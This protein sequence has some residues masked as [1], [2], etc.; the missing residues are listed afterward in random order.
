MQYDAHNETWTGPEKLTFRFVFVYVL[1]FLSCFSFPHAIIPDIGKY[2]SVF[3]Q[4]IVTWFVKHV[5][6]LSTP[7]NIELHSDSTGMYVAALMMLAVAAIITI[8][9]SFADRNRNNYNKLN[10][11]FRVFTSYYLALQLLVYGADKIFKAQFYLPEPNTLY[12][13]LGNM[14]RDLLY[15]STMGVSRP[16]SI[17]LGSV[18]VACALLLLFRRSRMAGAILAVFV[19]ANIV[20]INF[21]FDIS[22]KL[23]SLYLLALALLLVWPYAYARLRNRQ[24]KLWLPSFDSKQ[25]RGIYISIKVACVILI[26]ADASWAY[27]H[28]SNFN[29]DT[30]PRPFLHGAY[31]V[32]LFV[33]NNDTLPPL[34]TDTARWRRMFIHRRGYFIAQHMNDELKD[35]TLIYDTAN[36][37]LMISDAR[38]RPQGLF[39]YERPNDSAL[40]LHGD[41]G[42][43]SVNIYLRKLDEGRLRLYNAPF[44][45][46]S[47]E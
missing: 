20:A 21:C 10:Y 4:P 39:Q 5:L 24:V 13:A 43:D 46:R 31:Q 14:P 41:L 30:A 17:F 36:K 2:T 11:W 3:W 26:F 22:V 28:N 44:H 33:R 6:H 15:W 27:V 47:D 29:D 38:D 19:L 8:A 32:T 34:E 7:R 35:Y 18:E 12:T 25:Q 16:Y 42:A 45:R 9:W 37:Y 23:Y 40:V 1:C